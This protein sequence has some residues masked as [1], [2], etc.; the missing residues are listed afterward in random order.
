MEPVALDQLPM[1]DFE[2]FYRTFASSSLSSDGLP[3]LTVETSRGCWWGEK[4]H[5]TFC[6][7]NGTAMRYRQKNW[8]R[9]AEE[10]DYLSTR[11][12]PAVVQFADNILSMDY[13][14]NLLPFWLNEK[15]LTAQPGNAVLDA[16]RCKKAKRLRR[17]IFQAVSNHLANGCGGLQCTETATLT[18]PFR[19]SLADALGA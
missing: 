7:L 3:N 14:K 13:F 16:A 15:E 1:P 4:S 19:Y 6:G 17:G 2:D 9:V 10:V 5:C 12:N 11:Y 18:V 8:K